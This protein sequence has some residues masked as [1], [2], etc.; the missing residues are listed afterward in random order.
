MSRSCSGVYDCEG[1]VGTAEVRRVYSDCISLVRMKMEETSLFGVWCFGASSAKSLVQRSDH[2]TDFF[3]GPFPF[4]AR[5]GSISYTAIA[6]IIV[7]WYYFSLSYQPSNLPVRSRMS[8][9]VKWRIVLWRGRMMS[10]IS[11]SSI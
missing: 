10:S 2:T 8:L 3:G 5:G 7:C 6:V 11:A 1:I 9:V 4:A